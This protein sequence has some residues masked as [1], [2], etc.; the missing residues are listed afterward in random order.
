MSLSCAE[1]TREK[2]KETVE[3]FFM[4]HRKKELLVSIYLDTEGKKPI[5]NFHI[6]SDHQ[7]VTEDSTQTELIISDFISKSLMPDDV[8]IQ[9]EEVVKCEVEVRTGETEEDIVANVLEIMFKNGTVLEVGF[10]NI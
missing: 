8:T 1:L 6:A 7:E 10:L 9:Y 5:C 3:D 2:I 4:E